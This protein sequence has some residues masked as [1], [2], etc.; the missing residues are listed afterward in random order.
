MIFF[1]FKHAG[2]CL[3]KKK[4]QE[5]FNREILWCATVR[6]RRT[7]GKSRF[8]AITWQLVIRDVDSVVFHKRDARLLNDT[9]LTQFNKSLSTLWVTSERA[10]YCYTQWAENPDGKRICA[11]P[12]VESDRMYPRSRAYYRVHI[13]R[14]THSHN[15]T[16]FPVIQRGLLS[17]GSRGEN[18]RSR[19]ALKQLFYKE[20]RIC[21]A[22]T[23]AT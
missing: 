3:I 5:S 11:A 12:C 18:N 19:R 16:I 10:N 4:Q 2:Q 9:R 1:L 13:R 6:W 20:M 17:T 8:A 23:E 22:T 14:V 21:V 7:K 15:R